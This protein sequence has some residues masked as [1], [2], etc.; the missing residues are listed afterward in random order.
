MN[1]AFLGTFK[2]GSLPGMIANNT[3]SRL[4]SRLYFRFL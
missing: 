3:R 2:V 1:V 4:A